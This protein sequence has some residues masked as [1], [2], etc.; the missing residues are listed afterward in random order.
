M[1]KNRLS[2]IL[3]NIISSVQ[4]AFV[5]DRIINDNILLAQELIQS[6]KKKV[7]GFNMIMKLDIT[8]AYY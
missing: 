5:K 1:L 8:K 2:S 4:C 3:P 7:R 6:I